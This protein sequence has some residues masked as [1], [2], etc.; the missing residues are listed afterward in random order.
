[1]NKPQPLCQRHKRSLF[2]PCFSDSLVHTNRLKGHFQPAWHR[3]S[4]STPSTPG[5]QQLQEG[6]QSRARAGQRRFRNFYG[7][8]TIWAWSKELKGLF[9][10][11][12]IAPWQ[13][14]SQPGPQ[15][16]APSCPGSVDRRGSSQLQ[17][18]FIFFLPRASKR[19]LIAKTIENVYN[20]M[21]TIRNC[22]VF[23]ATPVPRSSFAQETSCKFEEEEAEISG[24]AHVPRETP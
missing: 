22:I 9:L 14:C 2:S 11:R 6:Q 10:D 3:L 4:L 18:Y 7:I 13:G 24:T 16:A 19:G 12:T 17:G 21:K 20:K 15:P 5:S 8:R 1:M 23:S